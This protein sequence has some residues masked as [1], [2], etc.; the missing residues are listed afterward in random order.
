M[1]PQHEGR[2][3]HLQQSSKVRYPEGTEAGCPTLL[4]VFVGFHAKQCG[5]KG[6]VSLFRITLRP[7]RPYTP[8]SGYRPDIFSFGLALAARDPVSSWR[9]AGVSGRAGFDDLGDVCLFGAWCPV[10][11]GPSASFRPWKSGRLEVC[12]ILTGGLGSRPAPLFFGLR[13][14][15]VEF[16]HEAQSACL[17][18]WPGLAESSRMLH[19]S[20]KILHIS[21]SA[22]DASSL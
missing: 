12:G 8:R 10:L 16:Q 6:R 22:L 2:I 3:P 7:T 11:L 5:F 1:H 13:F 9:G 20:F 15:S 4:G 18:P 14:L 17:C 19:T 21:L